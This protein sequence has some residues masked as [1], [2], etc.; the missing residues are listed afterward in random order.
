MDTI[1]EIKQKLSIVDIVGSYVQLQKAGRNYRSTC[2]FHVE[3][4]PSFMVS[5]E[6]QIYKCFGCGA[7]GDMFNFVQ[8]IEG[9]EFFDALNLLADRAGVEVKKTQS[10]PNKSKKDLIYKINSEAA[11]FYHYLLTQHNSGKDALK[12]AIETRKLSKETIENFAVGYAPETWD[13]LTKY[14]QKKGFKISDLELAGVAVKRNTGNGY[15]DK[16]RGRLM[17]PLVNIDGKIVG[18]TGR[19]LNPENSPKY[20]NSPETLVFLKNSYIYG[21]DKAK[22][23]IKQYGAVFVEGQ[24]DVLSSHQAGIKNVVASSGTSLTEQQLRLLS[25]F[26][27][28]ITFCFDSDTAGINAI[29]RAIALAEKLDFNIKVAMIPSKYTDLD[30]LLKAD[31][32]EAARILEDSIPVYDFFIINA[33]NSHNRKSSLGKKNIVREI[34]P[35]LR[36][37]QDN[38]MLDHY[39]NKL[40]NDLE[41]SKDV[42]SDMLT[43]PSDID[44][45]D[46]KDTSDDT[47]VLETKKRSNQEYMLA[48]LLHADLD[49]AQTMLYKLGQRDFTNTQLNDIFVELKN[50][51]LGRKRKFDIQYF[52]KRFSKELKEIIENLYLWDLSHITDSPA[53][54][55]RELEATYERIKKDTVKRDLKELSSKIKIAEENNDKKQLQELSQKFN[56]LSGKLI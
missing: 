39:L 15:I 33:F 44:S 51:M 22:I 2:P 54:F 25:R 42:L 47:V 7:S 41:I 20:L 52:S 38:I 46:Y 53:T 40:S 36:K 50:Y 34:M 24:M 23:D 9:I 12:Y 16:F 4:T 8:N 48:L 5:P 13:L 29:K 26:T 3:K 32:K 56:E 17:F 10:D 31:K 27:N 43:K 1:E 18:F 30:E 37:I 14:L 19:V 49:T 45:H 11:K 28:D 21:L 6:L 55:S 35:E